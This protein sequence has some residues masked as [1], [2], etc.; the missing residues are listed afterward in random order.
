MANGRIAFAEM[1]PPAEDRPW[2]EHCVRL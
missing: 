1:S 2:P